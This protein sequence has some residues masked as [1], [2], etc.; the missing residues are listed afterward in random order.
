MADRVSGSQRFLCL[1]Y[2]FCA[3]TLDDTVA[4]SATKKSHID[5]FKSELRRFIVLPLSSRALIRYFISEYY[6]FNGHHIRTQF[7]CHC[8]G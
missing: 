3:T 5:E 4:Y 1:Q 2:D 6:T 7:D 8:R